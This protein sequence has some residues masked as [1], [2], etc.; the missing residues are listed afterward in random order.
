MSG[1]QPVLLCAGAVLHTIVTVW[2]VVVALMLPLRGS[3]AMFSVTAAAKC[4]HSW[5]RCSV[6]C[7]YCC[8]ALPLL[9]SDAVYNVAIA[10]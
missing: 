1:R 4:C 9:G 2:P 10:A 6:Q 3:H 7:H 8:I 5:H